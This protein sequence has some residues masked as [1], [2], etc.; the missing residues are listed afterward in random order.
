[1]ARTRSTKTARKGRSGGKSGGASSKGRRNAMHAESEGL[2][3]RWREILSLVLLGTTTFLTLSAVS[4]GQG[5]NLC[6]PAGEALA[7]FLLGSFGYASWLVVGC[8]A[9]WGCVLFTASEVPSFSVRGAGLILC[10]VSLS[11]LLAHLFGDSSGSYPAGGI[12]GEY[13][14]A[15]LIVAG[16]LGVVGARIVLV[17]LTLITFVL[18]TDI[19]YYTALMTGAR[20]MKDKGAV[21]QAAAAEAASVRRKKQEERKS[22]VKPQ[23]PEVVEPEGVEDEDWGDDEELALAAAAEEE[24]EE[25]YED[26]DE[27]EYEDEDE[28]E[29]EDEEEGEEG[30]EEEYE[31]EDEEDE[32]D[33]EEA[34]DDLGSDEALAAIS[35]PPKVR[36]MGDGKSAAQLNP[37]G[38]IAEIERAAPCE[39]LFPAQEILDEQEMIDQGELD[40]LLAEKNVDT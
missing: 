31:E 15:Q 2:S 19:A 14:N 34:A 3:P 29:Y 4:A 28:E 11:A 25:E 38:D 32:E 40:T 20:W 7:G 30:E 21:V 35:G 39:Y 23:R 18:A 22:R 12:V 16:G 26:E 9:V 5:D 8:F 10:M 24:E 37:E 33:G 6:G 17:V 27:E 1:M 13:I 36:E